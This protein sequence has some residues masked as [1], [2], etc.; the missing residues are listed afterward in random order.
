MNPSSFKRMLS[1]TVWGMIAKLLD[2]L[3]KFF[4]I[5]MLVGFYGKMDYGLIALAFSLNAYLRLMDLGMNVGSIR[6]FSMWIGQKEWGKIAKVSRSSMVFYGGIGI[7]NS[8]AFIYLSESGADFFRLSESQIPVF[9]VMMYS[10]AFSTI[11]N[12]LSNVFTQ[13]LNAFGEQGFV[14][15]ITVLSSLANFLV[16]LLAVRIG[17]SLQTYFFLYILST[18]IPI[19]FN[20]YKLKVFKMPILDLISPKW[21]GKAF[22]EI[23]GYSIG[24]FI[25]GM[26]QF[27]ADSLRP[28]LLGKYAS[29]GIEVLTEYRVIQTIAMLVTA[30]GAVFMQVLLP[31]ASKIYAENDR[32]KL[33]VLVY[34][35]TKYIT[36]FL[37]AVVFLLMVN[38]TSILTIYMGVE[39]LDLVLWLN[40]WLFTVLI[41]MQNA[42]IGSLVLSTGKT[43][44][45]IYMSAFSCLVTVPVTI[46]LAKQYNVGAA[47]IAYLIYTILQITFYYIYY[48]PKILRLDYKRLLLKS[49]LPTITIGVLGTCFTLY[50]ASWINLTNEYLKIAISSIIFLVFFFS[51]IFL[52]VISKDEISTLKEKIIKN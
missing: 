38:S 15:K 26:F 14:N 21:N 48:I 49:S 28:I 34:D 35:G 13:L 1:G 17:L 37:S 52:L 18:L 11:F 7:V 39:Y 19:P 27:S 45:L 41:L 8:A 20:I 46:I 47:V 12:W 6:F 5:P 44:P 32:K 36:V 25:M 42:P 3:A 43:K 10:L 9:R 16:A 24:I 4:T 31:S 23:L 33:G 22:K 30:F 50:L 51:F 2:A 29:K 40:I